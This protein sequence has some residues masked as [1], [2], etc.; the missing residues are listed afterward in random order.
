[1]DALQRGIITLLR[2][3]LTGESLCLPEGFDLKE[4]YSQMTRHCV[5]ELCY[6]GAVNC[7]VDKKLPIM[8]KL[9]QDYA[10]Q[11][12]CSERQMNALRTLLQDF[13]KNGIDYLLLKGSVLK[14]LY[15]SPELR[16][17][18][19]ADILIRNEQYHKIRL[20][21]AEL[22]FAEKAVGPYDYTW[23]LPELH[24]ELHYRLAS[25][26]DVEFLGYF[27]D[28]WRRS[29]KTEKPCCYAYSIEDHLIYLFMH[30][31]KHYRD[32]GIGLKHAVD[33]WV[34]A[35]AYPEMNGLYLKQELSKL[36][37][38]EFYC[39]IQNMLQTWFSGS[40]ADEKTSFIT[41]VIFES[42]AF[43]AHETFL[44]STGVRAA[45]R[46]GSSRTAQLRRAADVM[47]PSRETMTKRYPMLGKR[48]ALLPIMWIVRGLRV[49]AVQPE[50]IRQQK[51][52]IAVATAEK[53]D[54][55]QQA[56]NYVGLDF[57]FKED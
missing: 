25:P 7:G 19:D 23:D 29:K 48:P 12:I 14:Q 40:T 6:L 43:G 57:H 5:Q 9:F 39:N 49:L 18:G 2:S 47:F 44:V 15:P 54:A 21:M 35:K 51:N 30:F 33:L 38:W 24:T 45:K 11:M 52:Q 28:G 46:S 55:Y 8:Q 27:G 32:S 10:K 53:I 36:H 26:A 34:Y 37:L 20:I 22:G 42:G 56:L 17:M 41:N 16:Q 13:E 50:K 1:M 3:G 31:A 4:A